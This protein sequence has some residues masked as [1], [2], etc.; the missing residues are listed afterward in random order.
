[1]GR[2]VAQNSA[3]RPVEIKRRLDSQRFTF[4]RE[5]V[6]IAIVAGGPA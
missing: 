5:L 2:D 1:M 6:D 3:R 4:D